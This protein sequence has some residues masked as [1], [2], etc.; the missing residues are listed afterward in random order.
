MSKSSP[1]DFT[2]TAPLPPEYRQRMARWLR[3]SCALLA[4]KWA[5]EMH[6]DVEPRYKGFHEERA[7]ETMADLPDPV[8]A[9]QILMG[10]QETLCLFALPRDIARTL[11]AGLLGH[12][13]SEILADRELTPAEQ[14]TC[15]YLAEMIFDA[16]RESWPGEE[17]LKLKVENLDMHINIGGERAIPLRKVF[18]LKGEPRRKALRALKDQE[19]RYEFLPT[20]GLL[21]DLDW[22][23]EDIDEPGEDYASRFVAECWQA[24]P[25]ILGQ[26]LNGGSKL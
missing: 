12:I 6:L 19:K 17:K 16:I 7:G 3:G 4:E 11:V 25:R 8:V 18:G 1:Y 9:Y 2:K 23:E 5:V 13:P 10:G 26:V 21:V 24:T 14:S 20:C 22:S 15:R